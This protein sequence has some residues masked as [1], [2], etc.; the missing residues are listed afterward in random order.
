MSTIQNGNIEYRTRGDAT[1]YQSVVSESRLGALVGYR[2]P[3]NSNIGEQLTACYADKT[4]A[5]ANLGHD[6]FSAIYAISLHDR[7]S[8]TACNEALVSLLAPWL[9]DTNN[10]LIYAELYEDDQAFAAVLEQAG[11]VRQPQM[12]DSDEILSY[13]YTAPTK[14]A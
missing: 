8:Q 11:F 3:F 9:N 4:P 14:P 5:L 1:R 2:Q 12:E 13:L 7:T 6:S 10:P